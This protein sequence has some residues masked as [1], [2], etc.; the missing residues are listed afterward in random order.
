MNLSERIA[1]LTL[2]PEMA[3]LTLG[4]VNFGK[5]VFLNDQATIEGTGP[6]SALYEYLFDHGYPVAAQTRSVDG[7]YDGE[8][9]VGDLN[10]IL[11]W[12][13]EHGVMSVELPRGWQSH[14][15]ADVLAAANAAMQANALFVSAPPPA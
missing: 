6:A 15:D 13:G 9:P 11:T 10:A 2:Q 5:D 12:A 7:G 1:P 4:T 8:H 3:S 14:V